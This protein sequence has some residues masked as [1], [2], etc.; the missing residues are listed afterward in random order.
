MTSVRFSRDGDQVIATNSAGSVRVWEAASGRIL[1]DVPPPGGEVTAMAIGPDDRT[2]AYGRGN[3]TIDVVDTTGADGAA[4]KPLPTSLDKITA[5]TF[6]PDG[7]HIVAGGYGQVQVLDSA[8]GKPEPAVKF[9]GE[10]PWPVWSVAYAD[11][12]RSAAGQ[13]NSVM[14]R[15]F[16]Y[17]RTVS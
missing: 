8:G 11:D 9:K 1:A 5:L 13:A 16:R 7:K 3:G 4:H 2:I 12:G 10:R 14:A 17:P 15:P 6:S